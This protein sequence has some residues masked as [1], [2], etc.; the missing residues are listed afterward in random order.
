MEAAPLRGSHFVYL[1]FFLL[2]EDILFSGR[3]FFQW[4]SFLFVDIFLLMESISLY[5]NFHLQWKFII[6]GFYFTVFVIFFSCN[7]RQFLEQVVRFSTSR[8]K[9]WRNFLTGSF[10]VYQWITSFEK[11]LRNSQL[12]KASV[13]CLSLLTL[14]FSR[15]R[16][17]QIPKNLSQSHSPLTVNC[18]VKPQN[19]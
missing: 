1:K 7:D 13:L 6:E 19:I 8:S 18:D 4:K 15:E 2:M 3:H 9:W 12:K 17:S 10:S 16:Q 5:E 14:N 11:L